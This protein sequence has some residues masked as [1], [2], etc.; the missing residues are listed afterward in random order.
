MTDR[1]LADL[2][3]RGLIIDAALSDIKYEDEVVTLLTS[4]L[5]RWCKQDKYKAYGMAVELH[6]L[7][8]E[9]LDDKDS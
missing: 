1:H 2:C 8:K 7:M 3:K 5:M 9:V 4:S 6:G